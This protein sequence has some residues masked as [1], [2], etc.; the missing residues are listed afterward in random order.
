MYTKSS[1]GQVAIVTCMDPRVDLVKALGLP[2]AEYFVLRN[3]GGRVTPDVLRSLVLCTKLMEVT[4]VGIIHH[5]DCRL[6]QENEDL[7]V[8]TGVDIDFMAFSDLE[9]SVLEDVQRL[10][11]CSVLSPGIRIWGG[12]H[13]IEDHTV[14]LISDTRNRTFSIT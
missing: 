2:A 10:D 7:V 3:A 8:K 9:A 12:L 6:Q 5:T 11:D 13:S 4:E 1:L 14:H